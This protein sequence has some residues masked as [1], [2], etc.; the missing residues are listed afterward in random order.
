[1]K[2][3]KKVITGTVLVL[4][5]LFLNSCTLSRKLDVVGTF[6]CEDPEMTIVMLDIGND[7]TVSDHCCYGVLKNKDGTEQKIVLRNAPVRFMIFSYTIGD[8]EFGLSECIYSGRVSKVDESSFVLET[9]DGE[10]FTFKRVDSETTED[11]IER[12]YKYRYGKTI[13]LE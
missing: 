1:M 13:T 4:F 11:V 10:L 7:G 6:V 12:Y 2:K 9:L 5:V 3:F 8:D